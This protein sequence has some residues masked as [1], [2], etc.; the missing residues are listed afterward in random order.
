MAM[1]R[2]ERRGELRAEALGPRRRRRRAPLE[3]AAAGE[4][5]AN[6]AF[7]TTAQPP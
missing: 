3:P 1:V 5:A 7:S 6:L 2:A 4:Q